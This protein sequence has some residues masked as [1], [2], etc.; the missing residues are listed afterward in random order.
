[1][2]NAVFLDRDGVVNKLAFFPELGLIDSPLNPSQ[3]RLI[4][5]VAEAINSF[6]NIGFKVIIVSN[7]PAIAKGKMSEELFEGIRHKMKILLEKKNAHVDAEY[8]CFHHP[9]AKR[10]EF[11]VVCN[12]RKPRPGMLLEAKKDCGLDLSKCYMIGDG[13]TDIKAGKTVGCRSILIGELKCDSCRQMEVMQVK[14]NLIAPSLFVA[15]RIIE[16]ELSE[17]MEV[18]VNATNVKG[19]KEIARKGV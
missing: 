8:Y 17:K 13:L 1:M 11:K 14:P 12:C 16:K 3:F 10:H 2:T 5:G 7:Q 15:S 9:R 18:F 4:P 6:N 19:K